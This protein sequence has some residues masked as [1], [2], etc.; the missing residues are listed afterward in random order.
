MPTSQLRHAFTDKQ[1]L[2]IEPLLPAERGRRARPTELPHRVFMHAVYYFTRTGIP[3]RDLPAAFGPWQT[4]FSKFNRW[5]K[6]GIFDDVLTALQTDID[7]ESAMLDGSYV[8]AHQDSRGGKGGRKIKQSVRRAA[9]ARRKST[10]SSTVLA[11]H[12]H[13]SSRRAMSTT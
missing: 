6:Q 1:W 9:V 4:V 8:R 11:I 7:R 3:W 5:S 13:S 10:V 12:S 2:V